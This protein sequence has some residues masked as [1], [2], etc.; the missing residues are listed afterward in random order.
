MKKSVFLGGL[1]AG[2]LL[3]VFAIFSGILVVF[4]VQAFGIGSFA[5]VACLSFGI[6]GAAFFIKSGKRFQGSK[7]AAAFFL[8]GT[9]VFFALNRLAYHLP[10]AL[11][12]ALPAL[13]MPTDRLEIL[14]IPIIR[15]LS[16]PI[17]WSGSSNKIA[18]SS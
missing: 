11:L 2:L 4:S 10:S 16:S 14:S 9:V 15:N 5:R 13:K 18:A 1:A 7:E 6:A 12:A 3:M 17:E 8:V